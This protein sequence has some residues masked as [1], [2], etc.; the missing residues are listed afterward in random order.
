MKQLFFLIVFVLLVTPSVAKKSEKPSERAI[1]HNNKGVA[2][3]YNEG[4]VD[5]A[6]FEFKTATEMEPKYVEA[7]SN[8]GLAYKYK[9]QLDEAVKVLTKAIDLDKKFASPHN[10][11]GIV[12]H[13]LGKYKEALD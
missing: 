9:G 11:L 7:W 2:A 1:E 8:L 12:Y 4:D 5:K 3:L 13:A 10:H 6:I